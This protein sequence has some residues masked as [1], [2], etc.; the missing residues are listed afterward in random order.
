MFVD[1]AAEP[2]HHRI[3]RLEELLQQPVRVFRVEPPGEIGVAADIHEHDGD[4]PDFPTGMST[5]WALAGGTL[6]GGTSAA[7]SAFGAGAGEAVAAA[8]VPSDLPQPPQNRSS[9]A[10]SKPQAGQGRGKA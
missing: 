2:H 8:G 9:A 4:R 6:A 3:R 10:F 7:G 1:P 5:P